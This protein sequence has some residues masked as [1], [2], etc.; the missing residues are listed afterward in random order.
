MNDK[1]GAGASASAP[2]RRIVEELRDYPAEGYWRPAERKLWYV[3][4]EGT[5]EITHDLK[6]ERA[7]LF[8]RVNP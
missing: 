8:L 1:Q 5:V 4:L 7:E 3:V 6:R 2:N